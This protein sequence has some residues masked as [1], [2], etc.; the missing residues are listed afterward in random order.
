MQLETQLGLTMLAEGFKGRKPG[1]KSNSAHKM[2]DQAKHYW[3]AGL[4]SFSL[5]LQRECDAEDP[6]KKMRTFA[7]LTKTQRMAVA[8]RM[9]NKAVARYRSSRQGTK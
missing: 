9:Y 1:K 8:N 6:R 4:P 2:L 7:S 5:E 3:G